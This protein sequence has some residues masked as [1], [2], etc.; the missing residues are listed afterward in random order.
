MRKLE[1][2]V[3]GGGGSKSGGGGASARLNLACAPCFPFAQCG[4]YLFIYPTL[5]IEAA[6]IKPKLN[7][8]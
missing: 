6:K 4:I 1:V 3:W 2:C 5:Y 8:R 7:A